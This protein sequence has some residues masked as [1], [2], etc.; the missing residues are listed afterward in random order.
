MKLATVQAD[1]NIIDA[2]LHNFGQRVETQTRAC[3]T[4][5]FRKPRTVYWEWFFFGKNSPLKPLFETGGNGQSRLS[6]YIFN[7]DTEISNQWLGYSKRILQSTVTP[8]TSHFYSFGALLAYCYV[9]GIRDLHRGNL[10]MTPTHLQVVDAEVVLTRLVLPNE[11]ILLPFKEVGRQKSG[12]GALVSESQLSSEN[13]E[14]ILS[15]YFDMFTHL[16]KNR[17]LLLKKFEDVAD[18]EIPIRVLLRNTVDYKTATDF[19]PEESAQ[20]SRNDIPYFFKRLGQKDL[21][22]LEKKGTEIKAG[23]LGR[24]EPDIARHAIHPSVILSEEM[25]SNERLVQGAFLIYRKLGLTSEYRLKNNTHITSK[26]IFFESSNYQLA[27][28]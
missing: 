2:D 18:L 20:L 4:D 19:L 3:G 13:G 17:S 21:L 22:W 7:L 12:I 15:G 16:I 10:I 1:S 5:W 14:T 8:D 9:F 25:V 28:S 27:N 26:R 24:F 11:T 6:D 23:P